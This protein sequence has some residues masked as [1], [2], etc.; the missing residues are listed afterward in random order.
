MVPWNPSINDKVCMIT[1][2]SGVPMQ[3]DPLKGDVC[4]FV[5]YQY[6][7]DAEM[8]CSDRIKNYVTTGCQ[9]Y[10]GAPCYSRG[11]FEY[12]VPEGKMIVGMR[13]KTL[14]NLVRRT[15]G[16]GDVWDILY[17]INGVYLINAA[18]ICNPSATPQYANIGEPN[19][20]VPA[21]WQWDVQTFDIAFTDLY[22]GFFLCGFWLEINEIQ[23]T[24]PTTGQVRS[25]FPCVTYAGMIIRHYATGEE[26]IYD[27]VGVRKCGQPGFNPAFP[28]KTVPHY[29]IVSYFAVDISVG[30]TTPFCAISAIGCRPMYKY[31]PLIDPA[32]KTPII[33]TLLTGSCDTRSQLS[34]FMP[35]PRG[36]YTLPKPTGGS[37]GGTGTNTGTGSTGT[38]GTGSTGTGSTG[39]PGT[40]SHADTTDPNDQLQIT[41]DWLTEN[42]ILVLI[43]LAVLAGILLYVNL[44]DD[45]DAV[46]YYP[47]PV[48]YPQV[49]YQQ[50]VQIE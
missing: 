12:T 18:D 6:Q 50:P 16:K 30:F 19:W 5:T 46:P 43:V 15:G 28:M 20:S 31:F 34:P 35:L 48:A 22:S 21:S 40:G 39:T 24:D 14:R 8:A 1:M 49:Q 47:Y 42:K 11:K 33:S 13:G 32:I 10:P 44:G 4:P 7:L 27:I 26:R 3:H 41:I 38:P 25:G 37:G 23:D 29:E 36:C 45:D 2:T 17:Q 9:E